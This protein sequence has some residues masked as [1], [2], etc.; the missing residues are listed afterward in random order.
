MTFTACDDTLKIYAWD[1]EW[2]AASRAGA[3]R[4]SCVCTRA[5]H[6]SLSRRMSSRAA[7]RA[8]AACVCALARPAY[9]RKEARDT[10]RARRAAPDRDSRA[11]QPTA[12]LCSGLGKIGQ[13]GDPTDPGIVTPRQDP[14]RSGAQG[15]DFARG[16]GGRGAGQRPPAPL[17]TLLLPFQAGCWHPFNHP[18]PGDDL[19]TSPI[20]TA[21]VDFP[22]AGTLIP[23]PPSKGSAHQRAHSPGFCH[24]GVLCRCVAP[25]LLSSLPHSA[26]PHARGPYPVPIVQS[27]IQLFLHAAT[28]T[29]TAA[30][31]RRTGLWSADRYRTEHTE[32][33]SCHGGMHANLH[34]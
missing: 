22:T 30:I 15:A 32:P 12:V 9:A 11:C 8:G 27:P 13:A 31:E 16:R 34:C 4:S 2:C 33:V 6:H 26:A 18:G 21:T 3:E 28:H 1:N 29:H 19:L 5:Q 17:S 25:V 10:A 20:T 23:C 24:S 14:G 7:S